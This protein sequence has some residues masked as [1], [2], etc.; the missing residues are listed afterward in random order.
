MKKLDTKRKNSYIIALCISIILFAILTHLPEIAIVQ[1]SVGAYFN[2]VI[3]GCIIA[4]LMNPLAKFYERKLFRNLKRGRWALSVFLAFVTF[5]AVIAGL[6]LILIPQLVNSIISLMDRLPEYQTQIHSLFQEY[7]L[8]GFISIPESAD[9]VLSRFV[10]WLKGYQSDII[11]FW[12]GVAKILINIAIASVLSIYLLMAKSK[13][14]ADFKEFLSALLREEKLNGVLNYFR[15]CDY[16]VNR[17]L[18]FSILDSLIVGGINAVVMLGLRMP[19]AG[20]I[21]IIVGV[22]N[23]IPTFGPVIGGAVGALLLLLENPL[24]ALIFLVITM[25]LQICDGYIIKPRLFGNSLG[26]SG[27]LI[28]LAI[29]TLGKAFGM[30]G[31]LLAIPVAAICDFTYREALLPYLKRRKLQQKKSEEDTVRKSDDGDPDLNPDP[32]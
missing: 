28:L 23:L 21:S 17:Y 26:V 27:L 15:R 14:K 22:T 10:E 11:A 8:T 16:I 7:G 2:T 1:Q 9:E 6:L 24:Y 3:I 13:L 4:Y 32:Q 25:V 12:L 30:G 29:V 5:V 19:H 18:V 20:L 31:L